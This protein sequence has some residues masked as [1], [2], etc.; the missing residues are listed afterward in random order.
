VYN[1]VIASVNQ[2]IGFSVRW[3]LSV[4]PTLSP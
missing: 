3:D 2:A 4:D 1:A